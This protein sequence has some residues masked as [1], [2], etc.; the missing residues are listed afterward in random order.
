MGFS[1]DAG[2]VLIVADERLVGLE[3]SNG[4]MSGIEMFWS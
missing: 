3:R 4:G 2:F 1:S